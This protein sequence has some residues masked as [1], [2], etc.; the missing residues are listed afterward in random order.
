MCC[1]VARDDVASIRIYNCNMAF[2]VNF[3]PR[4]EFCGRLPSCLGKLAVLWLHSLA[5]VS[6]PL[7]ESS[8][9][10]EIAAQV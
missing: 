5:R 2:T 6:V 1:A 10:G 3:A 9:N 7:F 4:S 8:G